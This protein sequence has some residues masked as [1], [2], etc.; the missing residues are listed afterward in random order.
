MSSG[1][2]QIEVA[3]TALLH[4]GHGK[5]IASLTEDDD[6]ARALSVSFDMSRRAVL[7]SH[8]WNFAKKRAELGIDPTAPAFGPANRYRKPGDYVTL[9]EMHPRHVRWR[10]E[11]DYFLSDHGSPLQIIYTFDQENLGSWDPLALEALAA[12]LA[13]KAA[14][15]VTG[16]REVRDQ[17]FQLYRSILSDARHMDAMEGESTRVLDIDVF[18]EARLYGDSA[19]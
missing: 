7:R 1:T 8:F 15:R 5:R 3:N 19:Y 17:M 16:S 14:Y 6:A 13:W 2:S 9:R 11:G 12:H 4:M 18:Q 10:L